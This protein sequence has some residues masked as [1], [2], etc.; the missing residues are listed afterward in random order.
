MPEDIP[1]AIA[2]KTLPIDTNYQNSYTITASSWSSGTGTLTVSRLPSS[3]FNLL[4]FQL[5]GVSNNCFPNATPQELLMTSSKDVCINNAIIG[6]QEG[7]ERKRRLARRQA[8]ASLGV[9]GF[10][11]L[12]Q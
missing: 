7:T 1:A 9:A 10:W 4:G 12:S 2:W 3:A 8:Q 5:S 6:V 11:L